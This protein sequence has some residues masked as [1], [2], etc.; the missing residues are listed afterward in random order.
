VGYFRGTFI[1]DWEYDHIRGF[2]ESQGRYVE[3]EPLYKRSIEICKNKLGEE[4]P[5]TRL[6][7]A[8]YKQ[9]LQGK[10]ATEEQLE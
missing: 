3:A 7:E 4:H 6:V 8:N 1:N 9:F 5:N 2:Y 10:K